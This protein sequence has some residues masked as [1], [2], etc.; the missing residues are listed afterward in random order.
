MNPA[1]RRALKRIL[2]FALLHYL[3]LNCLGGLIFVVIHIPPKAVNLDGLLSA[4]VFVEDILVAPRKLLLWLWPWETTPSGFGLV[5]T[6]I[7][8]L[9][10]GVA[11]AAGRSAWRKATA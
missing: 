8:S 10:W 3:V 4:L 6:L 2:L 7:N 11:L 9:I 1:G 5:L